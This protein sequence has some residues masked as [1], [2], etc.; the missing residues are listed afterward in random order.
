M[1]KETLIVILESHKE[2]L[3]TVKKWDEYAKE[4]SL[5]PSV[6]LIY[7]F[8]SW[9][10][11]KKAFGLPILNK[12][13]SLSDLE[14]VAKKHKSHFIRKSIWDNYSKEHGLPASAT[15]IKYFGSWQ[16][17][18][19]HIGLGNEKRKN[20]LYSKEEIH[21]ILTNHGENYENRKQWD[22]YAKEHRL[23]TYKTIK[24]HF[25]YDEILSIVNKERPTT[26][27]RADL[28]KIA[29]QHQETF[30]SSSMKIWDE[31]AAENDLPSSNKFHKIFGSWNKAKTEVSMRI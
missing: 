9:T 26:I 28:I 29:L 16:K 7:H 21:K 15:F 1:N 18:K 30:L 24:K 14:E 17:A 6:T 25:D 2:H 19:E 4:H 12:S 23:P 22:E 27:K 10:E 20:D 5:P 8:E 31:Y 3:T 11:V 13:Y